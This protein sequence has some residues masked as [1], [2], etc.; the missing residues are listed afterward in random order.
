MRL[1]RIY[2]GWALSG[3]RRYLTVKRLRPGVRALPVGLWHL[4]LGRVLVR[5]S[6]IP[7]SLRSSA[8]RR[9]R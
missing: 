6:R 9:T 1:T 5:Y 2:R 3:R 7:W 4:Q 8:T